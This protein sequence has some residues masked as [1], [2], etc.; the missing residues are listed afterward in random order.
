MSFLYHPSLA[1][2][3]ISGEILTTFDL[4]SMDISAVVHSED[5]DVRSNHGTDSSPQQ[6][7]VDPALTEAASTIRFSTTEE[8]KSITEENDRRG[9]NLLH[10]STDSAVLTR[11]PTVDFATVSPAASKSVSDHSAI[12]SSAQQDNPTMYSTPGATG[13]DQGNLPT[14]QG[15]IFNAYTLPQFS[16]LLLQP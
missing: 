13:N 5:R 16:R 9:S 3:A 12:L 15:A 7:P 14:I 11:D 2:S 1:F 8:D 4:L 10:P 6:V